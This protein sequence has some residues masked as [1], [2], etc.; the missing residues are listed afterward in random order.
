MAAEIRRRAPVAVQKRGDLGGH[1]SEEE[2][3]E[4]GA[5]ARVTERDLPGPTQAMGQGKWNDADEECE[6]V[7]AHERAERSQ[8]GEPEEDLGEWRELQVAPH[9]LERSDEIDR[10]ERED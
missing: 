5:V 2:G 4:V 8:H 6:S 9:L 3:K 1:Q 7:A 10:R